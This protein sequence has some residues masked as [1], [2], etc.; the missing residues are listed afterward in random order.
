[1]LRNK[2]F[3]VDREGRSLEVAYL[4]F[5]GRLMGVVWRLW[6]QTVWEGDLFKKL[7]AA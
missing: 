1:M 6:S 2:R 4:T 5:N 3:V 7:A